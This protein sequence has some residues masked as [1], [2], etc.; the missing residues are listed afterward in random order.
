MC[1]SSNKSVG[2]RRLVGIIKQTLNVLS[3]VNDVKLRTKVAVECGLNKRQKYYLSERQVI[4]NWLIME[5]PNAVFSK[6]VLYIE[7]LLG[8]PTTSRSGGAELPHLT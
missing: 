8:V 1:F 2:R 7:L 5:H 6:A 4:D 3:R